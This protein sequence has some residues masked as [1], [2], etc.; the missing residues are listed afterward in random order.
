VLLV[1]FGEYVPLYRV[2]FSD[3]VSVTG[4]NKT[5]GPGACPTFSYDGYRYGFNICIEDTHP[6]ITRQV[7]LNGA[8]IHLNLTNDGWYVGSSLPWVHLRYARLRSIET[9]RPMVRCT[10]T[11]VSCVIDPLGR[12][13]GVLPVEQRAIGWV[14]VPLLSEPPDTV[15]MLVKTKGV[16]SLIFLLW[17]F[18]A[19]LDTLFYFTRPMPSTAEVLARLLSKMKA[20][21]EKH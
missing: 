20:K 21:K 13:H 5:P 17:S 8:E 4:Q 12:L 14:E 3:L 1:P 2:L 9:R 18:A 11:G 10:N 15:F 19:L 6:E 16:L 7:A